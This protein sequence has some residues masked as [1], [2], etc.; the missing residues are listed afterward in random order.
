ML[1]TK[2]ER[3]ESTFRTHL[4]RILVAG[5]DQHI[6]SK[7]TPRELQLENSVIPPTPEHVRVHTPPRY[8]TPLLLQTYA[9][10]VLS[11]HYLFLFTQK[12]QHNYIIGLRIRIRGFFAKP[13]LTLKWYN[14]KLREELC[15]SYITCRS[16]SDPWFYTLW[17]ENETN[18]QPCIL[19]CCLLTIYIVVL[20]SL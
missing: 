4:F 13:D 3:H 9:Y 15:K 12:V 14:A 10:P 5:S 16:K 20:F 8:Y 17:Q 6:P 11:V 2:Q 1:L 19:L 18:S 7:S